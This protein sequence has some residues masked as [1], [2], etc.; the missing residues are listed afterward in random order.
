MP[1]N[2]AYQP[3]YGPLSGA[4]FEKQTV[5]FFEAVQNDYTEKM[6]AF[7]A[8]VDQI[9][10]E[11]AT[12][13][14]AVEDNANAI[15]AL[16]TTTGTHTSQITGLQKQ[17]NALEQSVTTLGN[18]IAALPDGTTITMSN[19]KLTCRNVAI[20]GSLSNLASARGQIGV[21]P[22]HAACDWNTLD[23]N[24]V[25]WFSNDSANQ[26]TNRPS[27]KGG[28]LLVFSS[29]NSHYV[30]QIYMQY[31]SHNCWHRY[32]D[33]TWGSWQQMNMPTGLIGLYNKS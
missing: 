27:T 24:A 23:K 22:D 19:G 12:I 15:T 8:T 17:V 30:H 29:A 3:S 31:N 20:G 2:F 7:S 6:A 21:A 9:R 16:Q 33:K 25:Y 18:E 14:G 1:I 26:S 10:Q 32:M 4:D 13:R 5:A 11:L 28:N